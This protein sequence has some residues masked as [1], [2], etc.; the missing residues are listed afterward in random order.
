MVEISAQSVHSMAKGLVDQTTKHG[1]HNWLCESSN[2]QLRSEKCEHLTPPPPQPIQFL[3]QPFLTDFKQYTHTPPYMV[4][5]LHIGA[6]VVKKNPKMW[7]N[8][9]SWHKADEAERYGIQ[10]RGSMIQDEVLDCTQQ[11]TSRINH[12]AHESRSSRTCRGIPGLAAGKCCSPS[13]P[14]GNWKDSSCTRGHANHLSKMAREVTG[15]MS[16]V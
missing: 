5:C 1:P 7:Q 13:E 14:L 9:Q 8:T 12:A 16:L 15:K 4:T 6:K 3:K 11:K 2:G 10:V